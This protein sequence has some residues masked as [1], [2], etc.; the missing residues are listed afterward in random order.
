[1]REYLDDTIIKAFMRG[2]SR[3]FRKV[4][5]AYQGIIMRFAQRITRNRE[6]AEEIAINT[7]LK[8]FER[9]ERFATEANIRAFLYVTARNNSFDYLR[10]NK[11]N[12]TFLQNFAKDN[13]NLIDDRHFLEATHTLKT[14]LQ[15]QALKSVMQAVEQL[16]PKSRT[17]FKLYF[18][19]GLTHAEI[20]TQLYI[21]PASVRS[22][23]RY[24]LQLLQTG[25]AGNPQVLAYM[26]YIG[27]SATSDSRSKIRK[28]A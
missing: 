25:L 5:E 7:C 14:Q 10:R 4:F 11:R 19:E 20:A 23:K 8:L 22:Q 12:I 27:L 26:K 2:E 6:E 17:V 24:A 3:A 16:P 9:H 15:E 21:T 28:C 18:I 13:S 1:M